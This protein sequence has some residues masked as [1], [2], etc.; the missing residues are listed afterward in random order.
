MTK[1]SR[2]IK[3]SISSDFLPANIHFSHI[4][5]GIFGY[6]LSVSISVERGETIVKAERLN[7]VEG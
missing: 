1:T 3:N 2:K 4:P 7:L 6:P 5:A